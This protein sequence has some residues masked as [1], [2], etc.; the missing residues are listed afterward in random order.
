MDETTKGGVKKRRF[1]YLIGYSAA[2]L[3]PGI[4]TYLAL[5]VL[6]QGQEELP[7][8]QQRS[9]TASKQSD[10]ITNRVIT[11]NSHRDFGAVCGGFTV[12]NSSTYSG[13]STALIVTFSQ[14]PRTK[15]SWSYEDVGYGKTYTKTE[16]DFTKINTVACLHEILDTK[17]FSKTC[18][19]DQGGEMVPV[20]YYSIR[21]KLSYYEPKT[22]ERIADGGHIEAPAGDCPSFVAY[23]EQSL[24]AYAAPDNEAI[25]IA[26]SKFITQ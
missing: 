20:R 26:H 2:L 1:G 8:D 5:S 13:K 9:S 16:G 15:D 11:A 22:G 3:L 19:Y 18:N 24:T 12:R 10:A 23:D 4:I 21:Y 17:V 6:Y 14:S 25:D 7:I